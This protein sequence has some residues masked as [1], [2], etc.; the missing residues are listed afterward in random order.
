MYEEKA[1]Q[2]LDTS[3][4]LGKQI[5][6]ANAELDILHQNSKQ[7]VEAI[8]VCKKLKANIGFDIFQATPLENSVFFLGF[9]ANKNAVNTAI[10]N[11]IESFLQPYHNR[12]KTKETEIAMEMF[13]FIRNKLKT[14][15]SEIYASNIQEPTK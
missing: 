7:A 3:V 12:P 2:W 1:K 11:V 9:D 14:E 4:D 5:N 15:I 13:E 6:H 10:D 8:E